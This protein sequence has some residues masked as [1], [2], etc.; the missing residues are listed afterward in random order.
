MIGHDIGEQ[1]GKAFI[2]MEFYIAALR[3]SIRRSYVVN[4]LY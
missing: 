3:E 1:D 4:P 2:A